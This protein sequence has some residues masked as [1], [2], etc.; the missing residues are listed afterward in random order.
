MPHVGEIMATSCALVWA[1]AVILF[2]RARAV[3]ALALNLFKNVLAC[4][5]LG[6]TLLVLRRGFATDRSVGDWVCLVASGLLGLT[7]GDT[8]FFAGLRRIGASVAAI[9]DCA[10]SPVVVLFSVL[11][12]GEPL[13][14]GLLVALPLVVLGLLLVSWPGVRKGVERVDGKGVLL[15]I[16]G[17][18]CTALGVVVAKPALGRSDVVEATTVRLVVGAVSLVVLEL[19]RGRLRRSL[20]IFRPQ[21]AWRA[22]VP[23]AVLGSYVAMLLWLGGM[24]YTSASKAALLNQLATVFL[25]VLSRFVGHEA[26]SMRRWAGGGLALAGA[27]VV[28]LG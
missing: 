25:L 23:A 12:L 4:L 13:R 1:I 5:L 20:G 15:A 3:D 7:L 10:Y 27:I 22:L 18:L 2:R 14:A 21:A 9:T 24:K 8:L 17:V 26:I 19:L 28:L 16:G 11:L 6:A